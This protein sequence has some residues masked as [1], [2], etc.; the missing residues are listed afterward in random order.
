MC[1]NV[2]HCSVYPLLIALALLSRCLAQT[3]LSTKTQDSGP[4]PDASQS[5]IT[6]HATTRMVTLEVVARDHH[7]QPVS[8]LTAKDFQIF[9]QHSGFHKEKREQ[10]IAAFRA[11]GIAD[12]AGKDDSP[13]QIPRGVYTNLVAVRKNPVPPT[14]ILVDGL[15]TEITTQLQVRAHMVRMLSSL[16]DDVPVAVFLLGRRLRMLQGFTTDS[17]L[18]KTALQK[19]SSLEASEMRQVDPRDDPDSLSAFC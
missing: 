12:F 17:K 8:G 19:A 11:L 10:K 1:R 3:P 14:V 13:L 16:P 6:F 5:A 18:L 4:I 7:G 15:N 2:F 9:D